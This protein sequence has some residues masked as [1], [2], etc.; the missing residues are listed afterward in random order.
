M[1]N[2]TGAFGLRPVRK[3]DGSPYNGAVQK[4]YVSASYATALFIGDGVIFDTTLTDKDPTARYPTVIAWTGAAAGLCRG[5][6]VGIE[7]DPDDLSKIYIPALTGG[8][9]YCCFDPQV[10]YQIRDDGA[11]TPSAVYP[12][13]N[14]TVTLAAGS[15]TTGLSGA[16]L[17]T[18]TPATDQTA[19]LH[20]IGKADVE[21]N[22][23]DDYAV[24]EVLLNTPENATGRFLGVTAS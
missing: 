22:E 20:I 9:V 24:W 5:V 6:I 16:V 14:A 8:Y 11:G 17:D 15:T 12:G 21:N 10:V 23:L 3:I 19:P 2:P 18:S 7:P 1:S 13:Q 4:C